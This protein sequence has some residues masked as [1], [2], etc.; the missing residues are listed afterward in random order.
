MKIIE[1]HGTETVD[2]NTG[3]ISMCVALFS[4]RVL[5]YHN[6]HLI[7]TTFANGRCNELRHVAISQMYMSVEC[8]GQLYLSQFRKS[9][10]WRCTGSDELPDG[11]F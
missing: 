3:S 6:I 7:H 8:R 2:R 11:E 9:H 10:D 1:G 5:A 4:A